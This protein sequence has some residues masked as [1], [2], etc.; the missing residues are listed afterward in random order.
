M[1]ADTIIARLEGRHPC[2][3]PG[4]DGI[5]AM[6]LARF[7]EHNDREHSELLYQCGKCGFFWN[8]DGTPWQGPCEA[9][10][11]RSGRV[12]GPEGILL[13]HECNPE[14]SDSL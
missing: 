14:S 6:T 4:C 2:T 11:A 1:S 9:C 3:M 8:Q 5:A 10:K 13:C 12:E 7:G